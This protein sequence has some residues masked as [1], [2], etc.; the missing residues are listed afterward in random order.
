[1]NK[2]LDHNLTRE[3][4]NALQYPINLRALT[5]EEGG[6]WFV[7]I[8]L[9]GEATCAADGETVEE[10]LANLEEYRRSVYEVVIASK[11][12]IPFPTAV[13]EKEDKPAG[14]WLM[15][16]SSELH[17]ALQKGAR[18]SGVSFNTYCIEVLTRGLHA[19]AAADAVREEMATLKLDLVG[20]IG[21]KLRRETGIVDVSTYKR[22]RVTTSSR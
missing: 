17:A 15:R 11:R 16:A 3:Q 13:T 9:L 6:G 19:E 22:A 20:E 2:T 18:E 7:T 10:A 4:W 8:P 1:M 12:P 21:D 14:K 5:A